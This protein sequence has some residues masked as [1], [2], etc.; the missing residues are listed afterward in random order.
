MKHLTATL[1]LILIIIGSAAAQAS[2]ELVFTNSDPQPNGCLTT[3]LY[4]NR[5]NQTIW[6]NV[7]GVCTRVGGSAGG[8]GG[9]GTGDVVGPAGSADSE[10]LIASGVTGKLLKRT[11]AM[12]GYVRL[13]SGVVSASPIS[14]ADL[15]SGIDAAKMANGS[16]SNTEFQFLDGVNAALQTQLNAKAPLISPTFITPGIGAASGLSLTV[17]GDVTAANFISTAQTYFINAGGT[18]FW[19]AGT[20]SPEGVVTAGAGSLWSRTDGST[21]SSLYRKESGV[22]NTGWVAVSTGGGGGGGGDALTTSPLSQFAATTSAQLAGVLADESGSS[23]GFIRSG[24]PTITTP[25]GI[26]KGDVGLGNIDNTADL[27]KPISSVTQT[28]LDLKAN[29][30]SPTFT[31][32]PTL[33]T[34]TVAVTQSAGNSTTAIATTAF[35]TSADNLKANIASPTFTGTVTLP[36]P[37]TLGGTSVTTTGAQL[38]FVAGVT[39]AIQTQLNAKASTGS[40]TSAGLTMATARLLGRTTASTGAIEEISIGSGLSLSGGVLANT[41]SGGTVSVTGAG[42]LTSTALVTGGGTTFVQTPSATATMDSSGNISTP[43]NIITGAGSSE[44]GNMALGQGTAT[45]VATSTVQIQAP[46]SVTGYNLVLPGAAGDGVRV[47]SN[48]SNVVTES[49][50]GTTG[51]GNIIRAAGALTITTGK[52][53]AFSNTLTFTGTDSS[54]VA[55]G[56]GGTVTYTIASGTAALGTSAIASGACATTVTATAT[57]T[58]STDVVG[59]GFNSDITS[60]TGYQASANGMLTILVFPTTNTFNARVCNNTA[61]SITP[62]SVTLNFRITR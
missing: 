29:I 38:N 47:G 41:A 43:G 28:A 49:F 19:K 62:G 61:S 57:G 46:T 11:N 48:S 53:A 13:A 10:L 58:A 15:P 16:V 4:V 50:V 23:G 36:S 34:G 44:A 27:S 56:G 17:S 42:A 20:G 1:A 37:F 26:V 21:N 5:S 60:V 35:V 6:A 45:A 39:S 33:P 30:G 22:G 12:T 51:S 7:D 8:G 52:T 24:S 32:T 2:R 31:G 18:I 3:R 14:E 55:L 54:S 25:I 59:W 9:S 40:A